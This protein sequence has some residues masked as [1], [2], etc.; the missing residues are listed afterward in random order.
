MERW[1]GKV[2]VVTGASA[3]IGAAI[4][5]DLARRGMIVIGMAR[6]VHLIENLKNELPAEAAT[7]LHAMRC[8]VTKEE[9]ILQSF[10]AVI[11]TFGGVDVVVNNAGIIAK[12]T[13]LDPESSSEVKQLYK[14]NVIGMILCSR[15]AFRS[16]NERQTEG[17]IVN[18]SS[19]SSTEIPDL[20]P[21]SIYSP[22][23][24]AVRGLSDAIRIE[25]REKNINCRVT[26]VSPGFVNTKMLES[27]REI[28]GDIPEVEPEDIADLVAYA[29]GTPNRVTINDVQICPTGDPF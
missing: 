3:G 16:M 11:K 2:A 25:L 8:D 7:R 15:E 29:L 28:L 17:H 12:K 22:A 24:F 1:I 14:T 23:K 10:E 5:K 13:N 20:K 18:I 21:L 9:D 26:C 6:R 19:I 27:V 4:A